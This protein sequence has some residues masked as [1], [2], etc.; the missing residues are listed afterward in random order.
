MC[1]IVAVLRTRD[2][3]E[4]LLEGLRQTRVPRL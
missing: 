2:C 4:I 3:T 1:G